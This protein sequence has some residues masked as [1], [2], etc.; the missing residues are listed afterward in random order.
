MKT[1]KIFFVL[2][3]IFFNSLVDAQDKVNVL[4]IGTYHF[5]NP[6]NDAIKS[7]VRNIL[8]PKNQAELEKITDLISKKLKPDQIFVEEEFSNKTKLNQLY[9]AY[10][11]NSFDKITDTI[12]NARSK[13]KHKENEIYQLAFRLGKKAKNDSIYPIDHFSEMRF[14]LLQKKAGENEELK[15]E[16]SESLKSFSNEYQI[17]I[18]ENELIQTLKCLNTAE[19]R[20]SN[21]GFYIS[22]A[23][24]IRVE[25]DYFGAN[26]VA[27]WYKRNLLIYANFQNQI[28][29]G[30]KNVLIIIGA[31]HSAMIYDFIKNDK[32][33]NLIEVDEVL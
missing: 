30:S 2:S 28:K 7:E 3:L 19:N 5:N 29:K 25:D 4:L 31:G 18:N 15:K 12:S 24:K 9:Q 11:N 16:F 6:G 14:D 32:N 20:L 8:E 27:N 13:K 23:N 22:L 17:C 10:L 33:F 1:A 26:L 21:K